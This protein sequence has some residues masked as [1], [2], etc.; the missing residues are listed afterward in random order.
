MQV[1]C[2][3]CA[4]VSRDESGREVKDVSRI[5]AGMGLG[6][7]VAAFP[8]FALVLLKPHLVGF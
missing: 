8:S 4:N 1:H 2:K 5:Q 6:I 3:L 7:H